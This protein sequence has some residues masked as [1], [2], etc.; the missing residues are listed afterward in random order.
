MPAGRSHHRPGPLTLSLVETLHRHV[1]ALHRW[2]VVG[3]LVKRQAR[4]AFARNRDQN[5]FYGVY[6]TWEQAEAAA[7][8]YGRVGYDNADSA[9]LYDYRVRMDAHDY[10]SLYWVARSLSEGMSSVLDVGGAIGIKYR[11]FADALQPWPSLLWR[12]FDVP[13][14]V[15]RGRALALEKGDGARLQFTDR[16]EEGD[17]TDLMFASG[18]LQYLPQTLPEML[19]GY[20]RLPRRIVVNTAAIHLAQEYFTVNSLGTAFCP[21]RVQTQASLVRGLSALGYRLRESWINPD[22]P[23]VIP[24][25]PELS[26]RHYTGFCLDLVR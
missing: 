14:M 9:A 23:L 16:F 8:S 20:R 17:G 12:V 19:A 13:A 21:Y 10:P 5:L 15:E 26:L 22:K 1:D 25:Q 3:S 11:A 2:P 7:K 18:V 24:F 4:D 6:T